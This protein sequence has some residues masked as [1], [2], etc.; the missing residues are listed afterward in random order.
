VV[1][2]MLANHLHAHTS[3]RNRVLAALFTE[4]SN[5][6]ANVL[7]RALVEVSHDVDHVLVTQLGTHLAVVLHAQRQLEHVINLL[8]ESELARDKFSPLFRALV[9]GHHRLHGIEYLQRV[10]QGVVTR[11]LEHVGSLELDPVQITREDVNENQRVVKSYVQ[12]LLME[13]YEHVALVP[14]SLRAI[15]GGIYT[16][17]KNRNIPL[18]QLHF[19]LSA[20]FFEGLILPAVTQPDRYQLTRRTLTPENSRALVLIGTILHGVARG[21]PFSEEWLTALN[22]VVPYNQQFLRKFVDSMLTGRDAEA[23]NSTAS[24]VEAEHVTDSLNHIH[25]LLTDLPYRAKLNLEQN[26]RQHETQYSKGSQGYLSVNPFRAVSNHVTALSAAPSLTASD[27]SVVAFTEELTTFN[28]REPCLTDALVEI[29]VDKNRSAATTATAAPINSS[30]T[31]RTPRALFAALVSGGKALLSGG[32]NNSSFES[33]EPPELSDGTCRALSVL[34][35]HGHESLAA[36]LLETALLK[37]FPTSLGD[38]A[39]L[40]SQAYGVSGKLFYHISQ[41]LGRAF[42]VKV[43]QPFIE[44]LKKTKMKLPLDGKDSGPEFYKKNL[45]RFMAASTQLIQFLTTSTALVPVTMW[46][47]TKHV[48]GKSLNLAVAFWLCDFV[49]PLLEQPDR[50]DLLPG[51]VPADRVKMSKRLSQCAM[52]IRSIGL[53]QSME[54][55]TKGVNEFITAQHQHMVNT[56]QVWTMGRRATA[57]AVNT[58]LQHVIDWINVEA[59]IKHVLSFMQQNMSSLKSLLDRN[60]K[61]KPIYTL[62]QLVHALLIAKPE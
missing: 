29:L 17:A 37:E 60:V 30:T 13:I 57:T 55:N 45:K 51:L 56:M 33:V 36:D 38:A 5:S 31:P 12:Q 22:T 49:A 2:T 7:L 40:D 28:E 23:I 53:K 1:T 59:A 41:F 9:G 54:K 4:Q 35:A 50:Y 43:S 44:E 62:Q 10:I 26:L 15:Y 3:S 46:H 58:D 20:L 34:F 25:R 24:T 61:F 11:V 47:M 39:I 32:A 19:R 6:A 14:E 18:D 27:L 21:T 8:V 52:L 48:A 16:Q 42:L